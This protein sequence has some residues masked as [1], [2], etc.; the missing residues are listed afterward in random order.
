[1]NKHINKKLLFL[2]PHPVGNLID[3]IIDGKRPSEILYGLIELRKRGWHVNVSDHRYVGHFAPFVRVLKQFGINI[4]DIKTLSDIRKHDIIVVKDEFSLIT[5]I[6][7]KIFKK[8][9]IYLDSMFQLPRRFWQKQSIRLQCRMIHKILNYSSY[10]KALWVQELKLPPKV[11]KHVNY[12][13]DIGFYK[14]VLP[15]ESQCSYILSVGRDLGR[16]FKT[17]IKAIE[18]TR[19]KLKLVTLPYLVKNLIGRY[20]WI[21]IFYNLPYKDL[22]HLYSGATLVVVPLKRGITYPSGI[23][24]VMESIALGCLTI[25]SWTPVLDEYFTHEEDVIFVEPENPKALKKLIISIT[26]NQ[27]LKDKIKKRA[28]ANLKKKYS[29]TQFVNDFEELLKKL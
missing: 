21:E 18:G 14:D 28:L 17:L 13:I 29:I 11:F 24:A 8:K 9:I 4:I 12:G 22:F 3:Q 6:S 1:M 20:P 19:Y 26:E 7:A 2:Y 27:V 16:D 5:T 25:V 23:R 15:Y 10:Q